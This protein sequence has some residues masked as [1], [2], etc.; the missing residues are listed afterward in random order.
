[1]SGALVPV[2]TEGLFP[3]TSELDEDIAITVTTLRHMQFLGE[4]M[5][6]VVGKFD[7][8]DSTNEF[9]GGRGVSQFMNG[10]FVF[11]V[12]G[13][14]TVPYSTLGAGLVV[15]PSKNLLISSTIMNT[16][17]SSTTSGFSDIGDGWTWLNAIQYQ[18]RLRELPGGFGVVGSY[19]AD[20][21]FQNV[22]GGLVFTP[23]EGLA[24]ATGDSSWFVSADAWQYVW[25]KDAAKESAIDVANG[26]QDL[27]GIGVFIR[28]GFAD[29][30]TNPLKFTL[31]SGIGG[32]GIIPSRDH[33][34][35]GVAY[36]YNRIQTSRFTDRAEIE[37]DTQAFECYYNMVL[38]PATH[39]TL[40]VQIVDPLQSEFDT[41]VVLGARLNIR[42]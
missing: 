26:K 37:S 28:A 14:V 12:V 25:L 4:H 7:T 18:Y 41:A 34:T 2:N 20:S 39:L 3:L 22:Q 30:D 5:A 27:Q 38:T 29:Q 10:N 6:L 32:K 35:M 9:A 23:G 36:A 15:L 33:D 17:D 1:M 16:S 21:D 42:F 24:P 11:P 40:N 13:A 19:A 31:S 8:L